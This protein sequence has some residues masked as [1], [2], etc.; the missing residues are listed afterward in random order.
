M[1]EDFLSLPTVIG[2]DEVGEEPERNG[3]VRQTKPSAWS[4]R[5]GRGHSGLRLFSEEHLYEVRSFERD[6]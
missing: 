1:V 3:P 4:S 5:D 6:R 2:E